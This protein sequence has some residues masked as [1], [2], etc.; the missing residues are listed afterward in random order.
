MSLLLNKLSE[1]FNRLSWE[2]SKNGQR[3]RTPNSEAA[4]VMTRLRLVSIRNIQ[5]AIYLQL[6]QIPLV[7]KEVTHSLAPKSTASAAA[8]FAPKLAAALFVQL[9]MPMPFRSWLCSNLAP[10]NQKVVVMSSAEIHFAAGQMPRNIL[11]L[12]A[13]GANTQGRLPRT[14]QHPCRWVKMWCR[15]QHWRPRNF[16]TENEPMLPCCMALACW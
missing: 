15:S 16:C 3:R 8:T 14:R 4:N 2:E 1:S 10:A 6:H 9:E 5:N 13:R 12:F 11:V 7:V